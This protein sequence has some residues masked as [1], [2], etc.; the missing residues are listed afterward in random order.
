[1]AYANE[2]ELIATIKASVTGIDAEQ[3]SIEDALFLIDVIQHRDAEIR[4]IKNEYQTIIEYGVQPWDK[5]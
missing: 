4:R 5:P 2:Q 3:P 1:M